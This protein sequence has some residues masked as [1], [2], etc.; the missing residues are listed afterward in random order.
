M[1]SELAY[2]AI[3]IGYLVLLWLLVFA[4]LGILRRDIFGTV[5]TSRGRGRAEK[6]AA[7]KR[8]RS[9]LKSKDTSSRT[10]RY[11]VVTAG[12]LTGTTMPLGSAPIIVGRAPSCTLVLDDTYAS[13]QHARFYKHDDQWYLEDMNST[14]GTF[15]DGERMVS[16][17]EIGIGIQV[18]IG[19]TTMELS[20]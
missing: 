3:R 7:R 20:R 9:G 12:P 6:N 18:R 1:T 8:R 19:Q 15:V 4:A 2:T 14:N 5:V 13:S 16:P 10:P 17:R 11:L